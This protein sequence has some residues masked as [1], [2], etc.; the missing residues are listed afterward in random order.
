MGQNIPLDGGEITVLKSLGVNGT[1]V[2]G[3]VVAKICEKMDPSELVS[4]MKGLVDLG[5]VI[6]E[7]ENITN[8]DDIKTQDFQI[9]SSYAKDLKNAMN[10]EEEPKKSKRIRRDDY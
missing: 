9:N 6:C 1:P 3:E 10:P 4:I 2:A 5:F 8:L 7:V